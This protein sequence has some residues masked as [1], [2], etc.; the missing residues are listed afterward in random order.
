MAQWKPKSP[1]G[2]PGY[3]PLFVGIFHKLKMSDTKNIS[4]WSLKDQNV[5]SG[6]GG[7]RNNSVKVSAPATVANL[8]C[9]FDILGMA[10]NDPQDVMEMRLLDEPVIKIKH[11]D[12]Y[13]LPVEPEKN[14][15]GAA[16][17]ALQEMHKT[18]QR[19]WLQRS[20]FR[21]RCGCRQLFA[22]KYFF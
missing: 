9:G 5:P 15:A 17:I 4:E 22:G 21:R 1:E 10:L 6:D 11:T 18:R 14:V 2:G 7:W 8:V 20:E 12:D 3:S 13:D 16:L 19:P